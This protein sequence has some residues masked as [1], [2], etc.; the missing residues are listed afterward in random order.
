MLGLIQG[1]TEFLPV[2][3]SGHLTLA[4][5]FLGL[6]EGEQIEA[7]N[8]ALHLPTLGVVMWVY[9]VRLSGLLMS[10]LRP[11]QRR[12]ALMLLLALLPTGAIGLFIKQNKELFFSS[13]M[14]PAI[15]L[16]VNGL[17]L[18]LF[19]EPTAA[20]KVSAA[21]EKDVPSPKQSFWVGVAQGIAALPGISRAGSTILMGRTLGLSPARAV[22]FSFVASVPAIMGAALLDCRKITTLPDPGMVALGMVVAGVSGFLAIHLLLVIAQKARW[23]VWGI[24]CLVVGLGS[25]AMG[26]VL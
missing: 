14:A 17:M 16:C 10:L 26:T 1:F 3:S 11:D 2:S 22:E 25:L 6:P 9:R 20:L 23:R 13:P 12:Y 19:R 24:Y 15:L 4:Q 7:L 18:V 5:H 21:D 8:V